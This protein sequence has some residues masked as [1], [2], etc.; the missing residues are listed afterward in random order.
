MK[1]SLTILFLITFS[2]SQL[3]A[4]DPVLSQAYTAAQ[5][6][7]PATVG[8]GMYDHRVQ[9]NLRSQLMNG[10]SMYKTTVLGW[11]T[12][13]KNKR[14]DNANNFLAMGMQLMSD[15]L[16]A[17]LLNTT[18]F[19]LNTAYHMSLDVANKSSLSVGLGGTIA[20]TFINRD[21]LR[22]GD[23]Y[24]VLGNF[25]SGITSSDYA[26][27]KPYPLRFAANAGVL[28]AFHSE[29]S[30][31]QISANAFY[32]SRPDNT[33]TGV[34]QTDGVRASAFINTEQYLTEEYTFIL[35]ASYN[36][37]NQVQ[38]SLMGAA[39]GIPFLYK[40]ENV[41]RIY[42][43][44]FM[45]LGD[46]VIPSVTLMMDKYIFGISYDIYNNAL[47]RSNIKMNGFELSL[48]TALGKKR[49]S[50]FRTLLN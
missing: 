47:S 16:G 5:F 29:E 9:A 35:H 17:G 2:S 41:N 1:Y 46:A 11:D 6:L 10:N 23:Q 27:L 49:K 3:L 15:Q 33:Y 42:A 24:D 43:G 48:S 50:L 44:C 20:Q 31:F 13:I 8:S 22:F 32:F 30:F 4:Q 37:R 7:S 39:V 14:Q 12:R 28:Y 40:S 26:N 38:Q 21:K 45:R 25:N 36:N 34:N 18:Y 19:T